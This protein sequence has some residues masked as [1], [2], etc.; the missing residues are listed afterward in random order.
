MDDIVAELQKCGVL[1]RNL[2]KSP[3]TCAVPHELLERTIKEIEH[4]R[5]VAGAVSQGQTFEEIR[6]D[7]GIR[8]STA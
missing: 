6:R 4:L 8:S 5:S 7:P 3:A 1:T 2:D